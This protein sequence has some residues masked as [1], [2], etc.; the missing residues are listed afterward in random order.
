MCDEYTL[1]VLAEWLGIYLT[2][3]EG[4]SSDQSAV[5]EASFKR[6]RLQGL[7]ASYSETCDPPTARP[8][9]GSSSTKAQRAADGRRKSSTRKMPARGLRARA[10]RAH[11]PQR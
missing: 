7:A 4:P 2:I 10:G 6:F 1:F 11:D 8:P 5:L 3:V 9:M